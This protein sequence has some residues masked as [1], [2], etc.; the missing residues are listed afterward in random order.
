M[1]P[2]ERIAHALATYP[3]TIREVVGAS[4]VPKSRLRTWAGLERGRFA[5][6]TDAD[7]ECVVEAVRTL[8]RAA[9][10]KLGA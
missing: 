10:A 4:G 5:A 3:G 1:T 6:P 7:A 8:L 9:L 2:T